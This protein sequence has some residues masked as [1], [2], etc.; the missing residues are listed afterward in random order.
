MT[1]LKKDEK[2]TEKPTEA[3]FNGL[4]WNTKTGGKG[5]YEQ[6]R[7]EDQQNKE[8]FRAL[9]DIL[10]KHNGFWQNSTHKFW[11]HSK[12]ESLID[13]RKK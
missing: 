5:D 9:Q 8:T 12:D 6:A 10:R 1:F 7:Y 2:E 3:Q 11:F 4:K 13:R